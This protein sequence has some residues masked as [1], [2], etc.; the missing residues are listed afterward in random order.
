MRAS[1]VA[2]YQ[3]G[4][5]VMAAKIKVADLMELTTTMLHNR[6]DGGGSGE[7]AEEEPETDVS[8]HDPPPNVCKSSHTYTY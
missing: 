3:R 5:P 4:V 2:A 6:T 7:G 8:N 1:S